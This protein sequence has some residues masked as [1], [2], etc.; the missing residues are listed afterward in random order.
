VC[1][2]NNTFS[3]TRERDRRG[4]EGEIEEREGWRI[5]QRVLVGDFFAALVHVSARLHI[6]CC[7]DERR[8]V[9]IWQPLENYE[10]ACTTFNSEKIISGNWNKNEL[11]ETKRSLVSVAKSKHNCSAKNTLCCNFNS[12][13]VFQIW[14]FFVSKQVV[15]Q[16]IGS[17]FKI[18]F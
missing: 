18:H 9:A 15:C 6:E 16:N 4:R 2:G 12:W 1:G 3:T 10:L 14:L 7:V 13:T 17:K 8:A 11:Q 5:R